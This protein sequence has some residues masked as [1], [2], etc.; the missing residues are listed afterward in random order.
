MGSMGLHAYAGRI[1]GVLSRLCIWFSR[2]GWLYRGAFL[3][4]EWMGMELGFVWPMLR[5]RLRYDYRH[6]PVDEYLMNDSHCQSIDYSTAFSSHH[7]S[8]HGGV[9]INSTRTARTGVSSGQRPTNHILRA[10]MNIS[11]SAPLE[12][13]K[14]HFTSSTSSIIISNTQPGE[15]LSLTLHEYSCCQ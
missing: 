3:E 1:A 7:V 12:L 15:C 10:I 2:F 14:L 5:V 11:F 13:F 9:L 4:T 6:L 8:N